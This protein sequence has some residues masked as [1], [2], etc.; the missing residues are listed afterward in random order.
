MRSIYLVLIVITDDP[1]HSY[2]V[3]LNAAVAMT[4]IIAVKT[5]NLF[6]IYAQVDLVNSGKVAETLRYTESLN[7]RLQ[8]EFDFQSCSSTFR[9]RRGTDVTMTREPSP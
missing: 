7:R 1:S 2:R 9:W 8:S 3:R 6:R 4:H 5:E